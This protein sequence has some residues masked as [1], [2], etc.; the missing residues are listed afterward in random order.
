MS[1]LHQRYGCHPYDGQQHT[2]MSVQSILTI[3]V[4]I[5][6]MTRFSI[7]MFAVVSPVCIGMLTVTK[8]F[9]G[10]SSKYMM[11]QR[12]LPAQKKALWKR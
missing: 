5:I 4:T 6:M 10:M 9:G 7:P 11:F 2:L 12:G 1:T 8:K 3:L